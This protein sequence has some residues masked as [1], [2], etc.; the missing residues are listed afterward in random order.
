MKDLAVKM[1]VQVKTL[2]RLLLNPE[3]KNETKQSPVV[4]EYVWPTIQPLY[5]SH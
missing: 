3:K 5:D 4:S 2:P 1:D